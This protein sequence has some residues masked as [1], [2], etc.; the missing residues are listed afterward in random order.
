[1]NNL[2]RIGFAGTPAFAATALKAILEAGMPVVAVLAQPDR[3]HGRGLRT[4]PGPVSALAGA[5]GIPLYQPSGLKSA[6]EQATLTAMVLDVMVVAAYGLLLPPPI[7]AWP[8][9]GCL[10][11]H[12]SLLPRWRGAAPIQRALLAGDAETGISIMRMDAGLDTGP[13]IARHSL[14]IGSRDTAG[15]LREKLAPLGASAI[16]EALRALDRLGRLDATPQ[17]ETSATYAAKIDARESI[18][19]WAA[20]A[21]SI[22]RVIRAFSPTP[23]ARTAL[24]GELIKIWNAEAAPGR[25]GVPGIVIRADAKG[26]LVACGEGALLV[27]ELQRAGAKRMSAAAFLAGRPLAT[28]A[29]FG[30]VTG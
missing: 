1:L 20:S 23:G 26:I 3:P 27:R 5:Q 14:P 8:K 7:L 17:T 29:R 28:N 2:K 11:I 24:D 19:D 9:Y 25:F 16:V 13:V 18:I 12:A 30:D 22:D 15:S 4:E 10:N 6:Q 21:A